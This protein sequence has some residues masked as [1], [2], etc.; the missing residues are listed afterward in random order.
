MTISANL[1]EGLKQEDCIIASSNTRTRLT[2]K[3]KILEFLSSS[4]SATGQQEFYNTK[5]EQQEAILAIHQPVLKRYRKLYALILLSSINDYNKQL[6]ICNILKHGKEITQEQ[7]KM[8]NQ[9]IYQSLNNMQPQRAYK[10]FAML[11]KMKVNNAR[12]RWLAGKFL[13]TRKNIMFECLKYSKVIKEMIIHNHIYVESEAFDFLFNKKKEYSEKLFNT[14][15]AAKKDKTKIYELPYSIAEGFAAYHNIPREEFLKKIK[16]KMTSGEKLRLQETGK[17]YN[18]KIDA[19]WTKFNLVQLLKYLRTQKTIPVKAK[20][21]VKTLSEKVNVP[22]VVKNSKVRV[23]LD[24]SLSSIGSK[25]K[26]YHPIAVSQAMSYVLEYNCIDFKEILVNGNKT[27]VL[28]PVQGSTSLGKTILKALQDRPEY[29]II[30]SDGYENEPSGL[31]SQIIHAY[32]NK[33]DKH[34]KVLH[35]NPVFASETEKPRELGDSILTVGLRDVKQLQTTF[36]LLNAREN[37]NEAIKELEKE[38]IVK[39]QTKHLNS[40]THYL[41]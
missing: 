37:L 39:L 4:L 26:H 20:T 21:I 1:P 12:T 32:K 31:T 35:F 23:V 10:T 5:E 19:D 13:T 41:Q 14:Y 6:I 17:K 2:E 9:I 28:V 33:I 24:N 18:V 36:F 25:E 16:H 40:L 15:H 38:L 29:L 11:R 34:L 22:D 27:N 30:L 7:K 8:E 3:Q